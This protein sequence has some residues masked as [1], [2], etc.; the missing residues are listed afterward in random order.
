MKSVINTFLNTDKDFPLLT[1]VASGLYPFLHY[2]NS[3]LHISNSWYQFFVM[4]ALCFGLP[5]LIVLLSHIV[6]KQKF[7]AKYEKQRLTII[8]LAV[9]FVLIGYFIFDFK[10]KVT[11]LL[12]VSACLIGFFVYKHLKKIIILQLILA[13]M[14]AITLI[15]L[16][17]FAIQQNNESWSKISEEV[18]HTELKFSP[19]IFVIQPDGYVNISELEQPPYS[20]DNS[21]F[22]NYL[23]SEGFINYRNFRSN[24]F[25]TLTSNASMFAM[26]HHQYSNTY[27]KGHKTFNANKIIVGEDNNVLRILKSNKYST[28]LLTDNSYFTIDRVPLAYDYHNISESEVSF[29]KSGLIK[30]DIK[31]DL[32]AVLDTL[33]SNRNFFFVEKIAPSHIVRNPLKSKGIKG[34]RDAYIER[35]KDTNTWLTSIISMIN[36][37][38]RD[39]LIIIVADHG[40]FVGLNHTLE[41]VQKP[42]TPEE[43]KS[44]FSAMLAVKWPK[45]LDQNQL[46]IKSNVNLFKT[47]FYA[48]SGEEKFLE[49]LEVNNSYIPHYENGLAN[50][51]ECIDK[52]GQV[53][54]YGNRN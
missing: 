21:S 38:D 54:L 47:V 48:L 42:L 18:L 20:F 25:S 36:D 19:N 4:L 35:L 50:F 17:S 22:Y 34:E 26:K 23:S 5:L 7:F 37:F 52:D 39:A 28:F 1:I 44:V 6:F 16:M 40:G 13:L 53:V 14:S 11:V 29:T 43:I 2:F 3:N 31:A 12:I 49:E 46:E 15:P 45:E 32:E 27:K 24:Y 9:F 41:S 10:K 8:N 30:T 33:K 51:Y